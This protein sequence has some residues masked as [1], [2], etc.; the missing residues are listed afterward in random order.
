MV[1]HFVEVCRRRGLKVNANES[2]V[3]VLNGEEEFECE[4]RVGGIRLEN[5]PEFK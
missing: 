4:P 1:R 5:V 2:K 3:I